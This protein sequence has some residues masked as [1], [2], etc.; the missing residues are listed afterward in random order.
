M[1]ATR[2]TGRSEKKTKN[3]TTCSSVPI[4]PATPPVGGKEKRRREVKEYEAVHG[5]SDGALRDLGCLLLKM[6]F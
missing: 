2:T 6:D 4:R 1:S 3:V 5:R